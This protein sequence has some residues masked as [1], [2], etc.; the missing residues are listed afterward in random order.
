M[1]H[2]NVTITRTH[3]KNGSQMCWAIVSGV[4]GWKRIKAGAPDGVSNVF[5]IL[6][7]ALANGRA[8]DVYIRDNQI[9]QAT[10]R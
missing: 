4:A 1:W 7:V 8:V 9:E 10:L 3:A 6:S 5:E 2:N